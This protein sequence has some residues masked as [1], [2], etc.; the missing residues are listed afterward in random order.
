MDNVNDIKLTKKNCFVFSF[1]RARSRGA[2]RIFTSERV[3]LLQ[4]AV[5][6]IRYSGDAFGSPLLL[7]ACMRFLEAIT[8]ARDALP[9]LRTC[10]VNVDSFQHVLTC[11]GCCSDSWTVLSAAN[12]LSNLPPTATAETDWLSVVL[13]SFSGHINKHFATVT[14]ENTESIDFLE[15]TLELLA[16]LV[17]NLGSSSQLN[18]LVLT[19]DD[20]LDESENDDDNEIKIETDCLEDTHDTELVEEQNISNVLSRCANA[21]P[22]AQDTHNLDFANSASFQSFEVAS[23]G[24][25][26]VA[27]VVAARTQS[28]EKFVALV[29]SLMRLASECS[30]P[31]DMQMS[32]LAQ[33]ALAVINNAIYSVLDCGGSGAKMFAVLPTSTDARGVLCEMCKVLMMLLLSQSITCVTEMAASVLTGLFTA[34]ASLSH[35]AVDETD[36]TALVAMFTN[37]ANSDSPQLCESLVPLL[38]HLA[39]RRPG[40]VAANKLLGDALLGRLVGALREGLISVGEMCDTLNGFYEIYGDKSYDYDTNFVAGRYLDALSA[41]VPQVARIARAVDKG[42]F[43]D[44]RDA[45]DE[46]LINLKAFLRYK[47][48]E[49]IAKTITTS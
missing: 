36:V 3:Q 18:S 24:A 31:D 33:R 48:T 26:T 32:A 11:V 29:P 19:D 22:E 49:R 25:E 30:S 34:F 20:S 41:V 14:K 4:L 39:S 45:A 15:A 5:T 46:V 17:C 40:L 7:R 43:P 47:K 2:L 9:A 12:I 27:D 6:V 10:W 23:S 16:N 21:D 35:V 1:F 8:D 37:A 28:Q 42:R 13:A 44:M 38:V